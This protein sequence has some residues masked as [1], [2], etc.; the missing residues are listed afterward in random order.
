MGELGALCEI[1]VIRMHF[2]GRDVAAETA[3]EDEEEAPG[4]EHVDPT[5]A[6]AAAA[7]LESSL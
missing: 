6:T 2:A 5:A 7:A 3:V 4:E 1:P